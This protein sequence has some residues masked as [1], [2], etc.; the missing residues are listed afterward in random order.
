MYDIDY[1][2]SRLH[3]LKHI[4]INICWLHMYTKINFIYVM[5]IYIYI[6]YIYNVY[7]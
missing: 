6:M 5:Y 3:M 7:I 2:K 1:F 4:F